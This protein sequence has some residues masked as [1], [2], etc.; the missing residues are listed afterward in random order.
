[1]QG[2]PT[3]TNPPVIETATS[4]QF[5]RLPHLN[6]R[7]LWMFWKD[8]LASEFPNTQDQ[9][10]LDSKKE[11]FGDDIDFA[12]PEPTIRPIS[13][14][15]RL[16]AISPDGYAMAQVQNGRLIFNWRKLDDG[17][18]PRWSNTSESFWDLMTSFKQYIASEKLGEMEITQ[19]EVTYVNHLLK[20]SEWSD[21][22]E[23]PELIPGVIGS[24]HLTCGSLQGID[25]KH[26]YLIGENLGRLYIEAKNA[27]LA[28][29][30]SKELL[31]LKL[32]SRGPANNESEA[33]QGLSLGRNAIVKSFAQIT[34][35]QA[36]K[37]WGVAK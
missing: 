15:I 34:G 14:A 9:T 25:Q 33:R 2:L 27:V 16:Q 1:M 8:V 28:R 7:H 17:A 3:F 36:H 10:P 5:E 26:T 24:D 37:Y 29:D 11:L 32:T 35:E 31:V 23:W 20:G 6:N 18:Y 12:P 21:T 4:I 22:S 19:W 30:I 13:A